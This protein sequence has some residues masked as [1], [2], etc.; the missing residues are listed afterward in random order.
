[1]T[2]D[3]AAR[4]V[5]TA[6]SLQT[7]VQSSAR[8]ASCLPPERARLFITRWTP[9]RTGA[10][11]ARPANGRGE[12]DSQSEKASVSSLGGPGVSTPT[13]DPGV[14]VTVSGEPKPA[15][16]G[17][18]SPTCPLLP[19]LLLLLATPPLLLLLLLDAVGE[20]LRSFRAIAS[21]TGALRTYIPAMEEASPW[22]IA[23]ILTSAVCMHG[24]V[25]VRGRDEVWEVWVNPT[26]HQST[27]IMMS[28]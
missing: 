4:H 6:T 27:M 1:M 2:K 9:P 19:L 15:A 22:C 16:V 23:S 5:C 14:S 8:S 24:E 12:G 11:S 17:R 10:L 13:V 7:D 25:R 3:G 20:E 18:S 21:I 26:L 28:S